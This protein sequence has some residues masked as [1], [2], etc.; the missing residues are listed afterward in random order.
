MSKDAIA[1][2]ALI[3]TALDW[4]SY[5][6]EDSTLYLLQQA[7]NDFQYVYSSLS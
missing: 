1:K 3:A 4:Y 7:V 5:T 2:T 6:A